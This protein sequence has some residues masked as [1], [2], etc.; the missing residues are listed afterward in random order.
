LPLKDVDNNPVGM[1]FVG[2]PQV[3]VLQA[4][5]RSIEMT[6]LVAVILLVLSIIP[7]YFISKYLTNQI[8]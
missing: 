5:G 2:K 3:G 7:A 1:L 8:R 6:F 4:A